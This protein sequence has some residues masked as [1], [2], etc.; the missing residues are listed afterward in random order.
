MR[1]RPSLTAEFVC[2]LRALGGEDP[3]AGAL[4]SAPFRALGSAWRTGRRSGL[5][6]DRLTLGVAELVRSRHRFIDTALQA[7]LEAGVPQLVL[8]GAGLDA[9]PWRFGP[10]LG[11]RPVFVVDHP[12]TARGR[13]VRARGLPET[14][15]VRV[16]VDF[17]REDFGAALLAAGFEPA[18][19]AFFVWEGVSM[20]LEEPAVDAFLRRLAALAAPSS[21]LAMDF[22]R[23]RAGGAG[24]RA[25]VEVTRTLMS[26]LG[27][28]VRFGLAAE[29][30]APFL[31]A[32]GFVAEE[33]TVPEVGAWAG[34]V[35]VC[36]RVAAPP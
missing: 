8:L 35:L 17:A 32:R 6:V 4:L 34:L 28:P 24:V 19:P 2:L 31:A 9:R 14:P 1:D 11:G 29:E 5:P 22:W 26:V 13:A 36:A 18:R 33:V 7:A 30:V 27:E 21:S 25:V 20:Y 12:A 15:S 23:P 3:F 16:D 10:A